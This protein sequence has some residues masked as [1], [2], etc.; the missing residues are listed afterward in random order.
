MSERK[1][2]IFVALT[3]IFCCLLWAT[4]FP[5]I[6]IGLK[7]LEPFTFA[8]FRFMIAGLLLVPVWWFTVEKPMKQ[9]RHGIK[10]IVLVALFQTFMLYALFF[11]GMKIVPAAISAVIIG[12]S[13]VFA[14]IVAHIG[15]KHDK[16]NRKKM[17]SIVIGMIG[18]VIIA[19]NRK[20]IS[21]DSEVSL[22]GIFVLLLASVASGI[23]NVIVAEDKKNINP[24]LLCSVQIFLGGAALFLVGLMLED[25]PGFRQ[26]RE[27]YV[28]LFWLAAISALGF[29]L[30]FLLLQRKEVHTSDL[31]FWKFILP[32]FGAVFSWVFLPD[33]KPSLNVIWGMIFVALSILFYN[34]PTGKASKS[35]AD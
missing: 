2:S 14:A 11:W 1:A 7:Y 10:M 31:N 32:V 23:G 4:A 15:T 29:S 34:L 26:P 24:F 35:F 30:W 5:A 12:A 8:G 19:V 6:K 25:F 27:C 33:E 22:W 17:V 3:A 20:S 13:P 21:A 16:L 18:I 28:V 9:V